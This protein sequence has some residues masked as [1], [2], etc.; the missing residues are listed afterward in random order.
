MYYILRDK[1]PVKVDDVSEWA[2]EYN[3][4]KIIEHTKINDILISTAFL[5][6]D[7]S[8]GKIPILFETMIFGGKYDDYQDRYSTYE[9]AIKGHEIA[10]N[11]V[12]KSLNLV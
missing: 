11:L 1:Q 5:G 2:R 10:C 9:E 4:N 6:I 8:M 3:N 7:H 12:K